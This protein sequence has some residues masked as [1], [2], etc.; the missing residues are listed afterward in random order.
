MRSRIL[1]EIQHRTSSANHLF[2][3]HTAAQA[4][5]REDIP[6]LN[7]KYR[8]QFCSGWGGAACRTECMLH[9]VV[10]IEN[11]VTFATAVPIPCTSFVYRTN[12]Y[13]SIIH[14]IKRNM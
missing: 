3:L 14:G 11:V 4:D 9:E 8:A 6:I 1:E 10:I 2:T 5:H 12:V 7:V 13:W